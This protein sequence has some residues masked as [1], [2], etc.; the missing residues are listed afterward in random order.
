MSAIRNLDDWINSKITLII[1]FSPLLLHL[2]FS[3]T[4]TVTIYTKSIFLITFKMTSSFSN[5]TV[6]VIKITNKQRNLNKSAQTS[7]P[8]EKKEKGNMISQVQS[9][10][11]SS[12]HSS[13]K[14]FA[15]P[16]YF[17]LLPFSSS[18]NPILLLSTN[19]IFSLLQNIPS[20]LPIKFVPSPWTFQRMSIIKHTIMFRT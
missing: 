20:L 1:P 18:Q 7:F 3:R 8:K 9:I 5:N 6:T 4:I 14:I 19:P 11:I 12:F 2:G 17:W 13:L 16:K 15:I 10:F